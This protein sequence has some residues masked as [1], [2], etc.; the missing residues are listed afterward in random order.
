MR[1]PLALAL[2]AVLA[3]VGAACSVPGG[4]V[5][6]ATPETVVGTLPEEP[7]LTVPPDYAGGDPAAGKAVFTGAG[8]CGACH[9]LADA[10]ATGTIGPNFDETELELAAAVDTIVNGKGGQMPAF[11][12]RLTNEQ[13]A[14]VAAYVVEYTSG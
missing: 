7:T 11:K 14:D 10:G 6:T 3:L 9:T 5:T 2:L 12:G 13:I 8:G 4:D 1:R